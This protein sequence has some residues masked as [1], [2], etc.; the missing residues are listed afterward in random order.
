MELY[1]KK[2]GESSGC[3]FFSIQCW[4]HKYFSQFYFFQ[5]FSCFIQFMYNKVC[6][7]VC[8]GF[9]IIFLLWVFCCCIYKYIY[10]FKYKLINNSRFYFL[11]LF[12]VSTWIG[13]GEVMICGCCFCCCDNSMCVY[14]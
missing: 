14:V 3:F 9:F 6:M 2:H 10:N 12:F 7:H 4:L 5:F 11:L 1:Y 8:S 13:G